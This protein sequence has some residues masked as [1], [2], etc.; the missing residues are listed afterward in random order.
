MGQ[1]SSSRIEPTKQNKTSGAIEVDPSRVQRFSEDEIAERD[2]NME[3]MQWRTAIYQGLK[4]IPSSA[5]QYISDIV[6]TVRHPV[7]AGKS[8][9]SA[10]MGMIEKI[11]GGKY[12]T[13]GPDYTLEGEV[14]E[15]EQAADAIIGH[16]KER[17]GSVEGF[18]RAVAGDPVGVFADVATLLFPAGA[19]ET[20]V[21]KVAGKTGKVG[22]KLMQG[23]AKLEPVNIALG[24]ARAVKS[25][26]P[27]SAAP[28]LYKN[29]IK[30]QNKLTPEELGRLVKTGLENKVYP[31]FKGMERLEKKIDV[32]N[33]Q[34]STMIDSAAKT[35]GKIPLG[36]LI[37]GFKELKYTYAG[38]VHGKAKIKAL[39]KFQNET[40]KT[41][42]KY[43]KRGYMTVKEAQ[44]FKKSVY[45]DLK[46][47]YYMAVD[48]PV[49]KRV[50]MQAG[51]NVREAI[52]AIVPEIKNVNRTDGD[53]L[54]LRHE[55]DAAVKNIS[56]RDMV[57]I[58]AIVKGGGGG[59]VG[60]AV[61]GP[62]GAKLGAVIGTILGVIDS[63]PTLKARLAVLIYKMKA[64]GMDVKI[65]PAVARLI[66]AEVGQI[67][68][69]I[70]EQGK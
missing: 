2:S 32:L 59:A 44:D 65:T 56:K 19:A 36:R 21:A 7:Q 52:E 66:G 31:T 41:F 62:P 47:A 18:K 37:K 15:R 57:S 64:R 30:F 3:Q 8:L 20:G 46:N 26:I 70:P 4:N 23:A 48:E 25:L 49:P 63:R 69:Q 60:G 10:G 42:V 54:F 29:A 13:P 55:I 22:K 17:Y 1:I 33:D 39:T 43:R 27:K 50:A 28:W 14:N 24:P 35:G 67:T 40:I 38:E 53:L 51:R 34:I 68:E 5:G 16:Y 12:L 58:T 6:S 11:P 9:Y 45:R 61:A